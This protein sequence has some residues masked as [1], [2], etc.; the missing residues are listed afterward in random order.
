MNKDKYFMSIAK[1]VSEAA[2]CLRRKVGAVLVKDNHIIST[3]Y[4]G[5]PKGLPHCV[6]DGCDLEHGHC[7]RCVHAEANALIQAGSV[8]LS[9]QKTTLYVTTSPCRRCLGLIINAGIKRIVYLDDYKSTWPKESSE[10]P[11]I[12]LYKLEET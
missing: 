11:G 12:E 7:I 4:N 8:G 6:D 3:G 1:T 5:A 2:T 9:T 10:A